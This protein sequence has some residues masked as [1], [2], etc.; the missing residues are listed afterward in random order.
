MAKEKEMKSGFQSPSVRLSASSSG[1]QI[2]S[3]SG[4]LVILEEFAI[5]DSYSIDKAGH[6][7]SREGA[8]VI[9]IGDKANTYSWATKNKLDKGRPILKN[10]D[11]FKGQVLYLGRAGNEKDP[12]SVFNLLSLNVDVIETDCKDK[13]SLGGFKNFLRILSSAAAFHPAYGT[14]VSTGLG[15]AGSI[16]ECIRQTIDDDVEIRYE[17]SLCANLPEN[18]DSSGVVP[19]KYILERW[20]KDKDGNRIVNM[21]VAFHVCCV[22]GVAC[23]VA[24]SNATDLDAQDPLD[25]PEP[26]VGM[27][28]TG[29]KRHNDYKEIE[30]KKKAKTQKC[31]SVEVI[32][33]KIEI[34]P[35]KALKQAKLSIE[36]AVGGG[37][38]SCPLSFELDRP[39]KK[40]GFL[41][42][43]GIQNRLLYQGEWRRGLPF[44]INV[45]GLGKTSSEA[46]KKA[47]AE[48]IAEAGKLAKVLHE[49]KDETIDK[50]TK[51]AESVRSLVMELDP[52]KASIGKVSGAIFNEQ[53][54]PKSEL[55]EIKKY[56]LANHI[57]VLSKKKLNT[58]E[59]IPILVETTTGKAKVTLSVREIPLEPSGKKRSPANVS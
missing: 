45:V 8:L 47:T 14:A 15:F 29:I 57:R 51:L 30:N 2:E 43:G 18:P 1:S 46:L 34:E 39:G 52:S 7:K 49:N 36:I 16:I 26:S 37:E 5:Q 50:S 32:L 11:K 20:G 58:W 24:I 22:M 31:P 55:K 10:Q 33:K 4:I 40:A 56:Q 13:K 3:K 19:G 48:M 59:N 25:G 44:V 17:G 53:M 35:S 21:S 23:D 27:V 12:K 28:A 54:L 6:L 41:E 42:V 38:G 9:E